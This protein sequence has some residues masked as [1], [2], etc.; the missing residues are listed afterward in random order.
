MLIRLPL[1]RNRVARAAVVTSFSFR[2]LDPRRRYFFVSGEPGASEEVALALDG[3]LWRPLPAERAA[4]EW[5]HA[6][7]ERVQQHEPRWALWRFLAAYHPSGARVSLQRNTLAA[8]AAM[9]FDEEQRRFAGWLVA[10]HFVHQSRARALLSRQPWVDKDFLCRTTYVVREGEGAADVERL[11]RTLAASPE[12]APWAFHVTCNIMSNPSAAPVGDEVIE[13]GRQALVAS[14][15]GH[16]G[17]V[18][19]AVTYESAREF[20]R[21][22]K[23]YFAEP[24]ARDALLAGLSEGVVVAGTRVALPRFAF[25]LKAEVI[26]DICGIEWPRLEALVE[27]EVPG[28][29]LVTALVGE[30][31]RRMPKLIEAGYEPALVRTALVRGERGDLRNWEQA[32]SQR[33]PAGGSD[34]PFLQLLELAAEAER[35][36]DSDGTLF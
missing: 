29:P 36:S 23:A 14:P 1:K 5:L 7:E 6:V 12:T 13:V 26:Y 11:V 19:A 34:D 35:P 4:D 24:E 3:L 30:V 8:D 21:E 15:P 17:V 20:H 2:R 18:S 33:R 16:P 27:A 10:W 32:A 31:R 22:L 25:A 28:V 9:G